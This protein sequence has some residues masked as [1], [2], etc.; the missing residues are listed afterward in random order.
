MNLAEAAQNLVE[1]V[2]ANDIRNKISDEWQ[3]QLLEILI[4]NLKIEINRSR[5]TP[6]AQELIQDCFAS[7]TQ[8]TRQ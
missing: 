1:F 2:E 4:R 6:L 3:T 7:A 8:T 5:P